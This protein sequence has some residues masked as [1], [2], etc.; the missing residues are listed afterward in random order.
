MP[1]I[2]FTL[3]QLGAV[4]LVLCVLLAVLKLLADAVQSAGRAAIATSAQAPLNQLL[5]AL[6]NYHD[7]HGELPPAYLADANGKPMHSWRVLILPY[8]EHQTL[9]NAY[10]FSEPWNGPNNLRL[11]SRMPAVFHS[12]S[13][14]DSPTFS[15]IV[16]V[17]GAG[18]AF[19][20]GVSTKLADFTD[21]TANTILLT[22]IANSDIVWLEPR[23]LRVE[24]MSFQAQDHGKP[25]ISC[26]AWRQ[27][28]VVF[29]DTIRAYAV[30]QTM[31]PELLR[32]LCTI[33]G[34]EPTT[35]AELAAQGHLK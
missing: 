27:P 9:Y 18:T 10:D 16:A 11:A 19:P 29:A 6:H 23:D 7:V 22:E 33:A 13:E 15:N 2:R 24:D 28:Y 12:P 26:A 35:R 17:S 14:P 4:V 1:K 21:G 20:G 30:N 3:R 34:G 32:A 31:P 5:L 25:S 8:V